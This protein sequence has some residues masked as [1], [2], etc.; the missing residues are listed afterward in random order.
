MGEVIVVIAAGQI[1]Q[2]IAP[3]PFFA[4]PHTVEDDYLRMRHPRNQ[5]PSPPGSQSGWRALR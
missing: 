2:A 4:N 3:D 5:P 1:G